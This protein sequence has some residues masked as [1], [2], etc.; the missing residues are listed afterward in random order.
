MGKFSVIF[1]AA[2]AGFTTADTHYLL[3]GFFSGTSIAAL[4]FDDEKLSLNLIKNITIHSN[5]SRWISLDV[6]LIHV[7][8][9]CMMLMRLHRREKRMYMWEPPITFRAIVSRQGL[10]SITRAV[11]ACPQ[12][13]CGKKFQHESSLYINMLIFHIRFERKLHRC[14]HERTIHRFWSPFQS[15]LFCSCYLR[16]FCWKFTVTICEYHLR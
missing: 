8:F 12:I 16:G 10:G 7:N 6:I 2:C 1:V 15:R 3:S 14:R 11:L 4:E 5:S 9:D 13:V